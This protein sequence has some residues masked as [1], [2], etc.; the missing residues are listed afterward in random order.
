MISFFKRIIINSFI[1]KVPFN[2]SKPHIHCINKKTYKNHNY[3]L[4]IYIYQIVLKRPIYNNEECMVI[5]KTKC[6]RSFLK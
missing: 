6:P 2:N 4:Q 3:I 5:K 1:S